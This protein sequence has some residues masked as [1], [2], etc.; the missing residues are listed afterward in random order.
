MPHTCVYHQ[1][2]RVQFACFLDLSQRLVEPAHCLQVI[3]EE[4]MRGS[5]V[6]VETDCLCEFSFRSFPIPIVL[7]FDQPQ[8]CV[9]R[10]QTCI[11]CKCFA[12]CPFRL[13]IRLV[14]SHE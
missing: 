7:K 10:C 5:I 9:S 8:G 14:R 13:G 6:K 12:H 2:K 11:Q 1:G 4:M 3:R